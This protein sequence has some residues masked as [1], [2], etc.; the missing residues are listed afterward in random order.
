MSDGQ[1][2]W[3]DFLSRGA[4]AAAGDPGSTHGSYVLTGTSAANF[5]VAPDDQH[6]L[7]TQPSSQPS[8]TELEVVMNWFEELKRLVPAK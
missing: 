2:R 3:A 8:A 7:M 5:D 6:F 4:M 1:D